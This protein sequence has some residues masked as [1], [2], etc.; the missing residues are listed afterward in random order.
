[1]SALFSYAVRLGFTK[2]NPIRETK[3]EGKRS[4]FNGHAYTLEDVMWMLKRLPEPARTVVGVAAFSGLREAEIRGLRWDDYDGEFIHVLRSVWRRHIADTKTS[5]SEASVPVISTLK[6]MLDAHKRRS[7]GEWVFTGLKKKFSLNLDN[8]ARR[9]I[10][11]V[12]LERWHGWHA[13]RR[14]LATILFDLG[15]PAETAKI[16][17]QHS[18]VAVPQ[19]HYIK[20]QTAKGG[21]AAMNKLQKAIGKSGLVVGRKKVRSAPETRMNTTKGRR[22]SVGRAADS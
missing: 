4:S 5:S 11:P 8:V 14:G 7:A 17:L 2:V 13:F 15:V 1:M 9:A 16:I 3:V 19:K 12:L 22:S 10:K 6:K 21:R 18:A 20:L